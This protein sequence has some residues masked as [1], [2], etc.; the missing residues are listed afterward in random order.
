MRHVDFDLRQDTK[1]DSKG[2]VI[3]SVMMVD[4][5][6]VSTNEALKNKVWMNVIKEELEAIKRNKTWELTVL[7]QN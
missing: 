6:P 1:I 4:F 3:H 7:P 2:E 5:E